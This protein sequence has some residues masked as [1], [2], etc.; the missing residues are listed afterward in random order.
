VTLPFGCAHLPADRV[1]TTSAAPAASPLAL[2]DVLGW[3]P[4]PADDEIVPAA[5]GTAAPAATIVLTD[6]NIDMRNYVRRLLADTYTVIPA[7]DGRAALQA[8]IEH[9]PDL[10]ITDVMMPHLDGFGL[11]RALRAE[12]ATAAIPVIMLSARAGEEARVEGLRAGADD[13]LSKPFSARELLA[14]VSGTLALARLRR[15]AMRREEELKAETTSVLES[16][17]EGFIALDGDFRLTYVNAAAERIFGV[18][19]QTLLDH[20]CRESFPDLLE[21]DLETRY[22]RAMTQRIHSTFET[23]VRAAQRWFDV[24]CYPA[25]DGGLAIYF[26][27]ITERK[28]AL[29]AL[30]D[31]ARRKDEFLA[32]LAHELRNP[33]AP[34]RSGLQIMRLADGDAH[35][36]EQARSMV[37]RQFQQLVRLVDDLFDLSRI[38]RGKIAL[39]KE[40]VELAGIIQSAVETSLPLIEQSQQTLEVTLPPQPIIIEADTTRLAQVFTNLLN[41]AAKYTESGG[42]IWLDVQQRSTEVAVTVK[43][44]GMGIPAEMLPHVFDMFTQVDRSLE[45]SRGGLGIGLNIVK[46]LVRMHRG[47]VEARSEGNGKGSEF[48]VRLPI[49]AAARKDTP[50]NDSGP[51]QRS[52]PMRVLVADDNPDSANGLA[53]LLKIRG[54]E[55]RTAH[56]GLEVISAAEAFRPEVMLL[57]IGMPKLNGYEVC[58]HIRA[59]SWG[60]TTAIIALTGWGQEEDRR[61]SREAGFDHH[62]VKPVE[63][64]VLEPLLEASRHKVASPPTQV[65]P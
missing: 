58:R 7:G 42:T 65:H 18:T 59:Q 9:K 12:P 38:S 43:D 36:E 5:A 44:T 56:D 39:R 22:R 35:A 26:R 30:Q 14:R 63:L 15:D 28:V 55:V 64:A 37:E 40:R 51:A 21:G 54:N 10:I 34:I 13:Y 8:A 62:L 6:D 16:I 48:I 47:S 49:L 23:F 41:N 29:E 3:L 60:K 46:Q 33:L 25:R 61:R 4:A 53:L 52:A 20:P 17:A 27:D 19:R 45:R 32:T 24:D 11:L 57:D 2:E 31:A 50:L 1:D